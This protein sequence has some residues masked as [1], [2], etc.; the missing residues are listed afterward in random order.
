MKIAVVSKFGHFECLGFLLET[1]KNH[2]ISLFAEQNSDT[3]KW[4]DYYTTYY[5]FN[6]FFIYL[7]IKYQYSPVSFQFS[8]LIFN[9][10]LF[11]RVFRILIKFPILIKKTQIKNSLIFYSIGFLCW[12]IDLYLCNYVKY[13]YF[14]AF[15]HIFSYIGCI[16]L[17][18]FIYIYL[19]FIHGKILPQYYK[20]LI[21]S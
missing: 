14:H 7:M 10:M 16:Y 19:S 13:I 4:I 18:K 20:D 12:L 3:L 5:K 17:L 1:I 9:L 8:F 21:Y 2:E 6:I 11:I 15:W